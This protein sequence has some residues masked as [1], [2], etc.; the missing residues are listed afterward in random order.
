MIPH[1]TGNLPAKIENYVA[2]KRLR[3]ALVCYAITA[4]HWAT[5]A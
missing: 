4:L 2:Q 5:G 3:D 1:P